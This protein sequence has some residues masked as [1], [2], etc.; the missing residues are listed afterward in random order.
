[1]ND[2]VTRDEY[3]K[4][5]EEVIAL[6][7]QLNN[8]II[9]LNAS[10][11]LVSPEKQQAAYNMYMEQMQSEAIHENNS[12]AKRPIGLFFFKKT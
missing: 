9:L 2:Y 6:K 11:S 8:A 10:S 4:L 12:R 5:V 3:N 7:A 1:M